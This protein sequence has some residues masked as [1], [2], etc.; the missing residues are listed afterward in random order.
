MRHKDVIKL[1]VS[2][3]TVFS[4][5][6]LASLSMRSAQTWDWYV[7]LNKPFFTP[8]GW[9][10]GPAWTLLYTLMAVSAYLV[11]R[12]GLQDRQVKTAL[13][14]FLAQLVLNG[15]WTPIFFGLR[16]IFPALVEIVVLWL[17]IAFTI[18]HFRR[19]SSSAAVLMIPY[20]G[21]V[22]YA[23]VLN[24]SFWLLNR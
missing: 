19:I 21:W 17:A 9:L 22:G 12:K 1:I 3:V 6:G 18:L 5:S 11:W 24:L 15:L 10:F 2:L 13:G 8:P 4:V 23:A 20:L 16:L 14:L 7:Q